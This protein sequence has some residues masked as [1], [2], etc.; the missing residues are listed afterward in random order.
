MSL[1]I[2]FSI[3][4]EKNRKERK[5]VVKLKDEEELEKRNQ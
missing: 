3:F 2:Y 1:D 5:R 4:E